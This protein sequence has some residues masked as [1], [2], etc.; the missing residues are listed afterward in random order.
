[1]LLSRVIK[2][3]TLEKVWI[4][5]VKRIQKSTEWEFS[6]R[7]CIIMLEQEWLSQE[8]S[9]VDLFRVEFLPPTPDP[10]PT[11]HMRE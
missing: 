1:M 2:Y 10:H 8:I 4:W 9:G 5:S 3:N 11:H 6:S 7:K